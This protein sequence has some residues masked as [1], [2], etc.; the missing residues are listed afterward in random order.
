MVLTA[1]QK[2]RLR[3]GRFKWQEGKPVVRLGA[4]VFCF[5]INTSNWPLSVEHVGHDVSESEI[6]SD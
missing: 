1:D 2:L 4:D 5:E 3:M 6:P